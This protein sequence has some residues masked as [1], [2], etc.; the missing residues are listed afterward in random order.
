MKRICVYSVIIIFS[1]L[2]LSAQKVGLVLSGGG[3]PGLV[4]IGMLK[5]LDENNIPV[6]YI[7][8]TSI[9]AIVGG[10][11]AAGYA[12]DEIISIFKSEKFKSWSGGDIPKE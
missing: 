6:N 2:S 12:P 9:G 11:Y 4:H 1:A 3:G 10:L 5:A 7:T 8:G